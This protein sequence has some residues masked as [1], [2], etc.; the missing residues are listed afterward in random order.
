M[1][2][3]LLSLSVAALGLATCTARA[4]GQ[5][6]DQLNGSAA[7]MNSYGN[8]TL[9]Q[10]QARILR[11]QAEQAKLDTKRKKFDLA[12]YIRANTPTFG[13]EQQRRKVNLLYRILTNATEAEIASGKAQNVLA[14]FLKSLADRG[15]QGPPVELDPDLLQQVNVTSGNNE[16]G[17]GVLRP[18]G[19]TEWPAALRGPTQRKVADMIRAVTHEAARGGPDPSL[20]DELGQGV[21]QLQDELK[22]RFYAGRINGTAYLTGKR[23]LEGLEGSVNLLQQPGASKFLNGTYAARG[24]TVQELVRN[25]SRQGLRFA[26]ASPG[27][28]PAYRALYNALVSYATGAETASG[29]RVSG[30]RVAPGGSPGRFK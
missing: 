27:S 28:E 25:M 6:G 1:R 16:A 24:R 11:E 14:P 23:F 8:L 19:H 10:E 15:I 4:L 26:P 18:G 7:V 22:K 5:S 12:A 30:A 20:C 2:K 21:T 17:A 13:Q 29:S 9:Q 3:F